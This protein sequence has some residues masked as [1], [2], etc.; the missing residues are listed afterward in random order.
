[1]DFISDNLGSG[2]AIRALALVDNFSRVSPAIEVN[3][4]LT[5]KRVV[6]GRV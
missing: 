6:E 1:M 3:F 2:Q 5:G 4:S